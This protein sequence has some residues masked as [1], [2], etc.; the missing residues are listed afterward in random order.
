MCSTASCPFLS[1]SFESIEPFVPPSALMKLKT[2]PII[3][4]QRCR[5]LPLPVHSLAAGT[6]QVRGDRQRQGCTSLQGQRCCG[7]NTT[8]GNLVCSM[9]G[10][11]F[12]CTPHA[13]EP[14]GATTQ[15]LA[16]CLNCLR[17]SLPV[18][19]KDAQRTGRPFASLDRPTNPS[20]AAIPLLGWALVVHPTRSPLTVAWPLTTIDPVH[21][22]HGGMS[23]YP[24]H[25]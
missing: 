10:V 14:A 1:H 7:S 20:W 15:P 24:W 6:Q 2:H 13:T 16:V 22:S 21:R 17:V 18:I 25:R 11:S 12:T 23:P 8:S 4:L 5:A 9:L 19:A 3:A